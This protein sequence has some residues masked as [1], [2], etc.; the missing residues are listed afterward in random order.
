MPRLKYR[1]IQRPPAVSNITPEEAVELAR[2]AAAVIA[3]RQASSGKSNGRVTNKTIAK[4]R[5]THSPR[6][7][8]GAVGKSKKSKSKSKSTH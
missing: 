4:S 3:A 7:S 8:S 5:L 1:T 2:V 6:T